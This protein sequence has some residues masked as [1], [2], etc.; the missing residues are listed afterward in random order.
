MPVVT[1]SQKKWDALPE[2]Q[3]ELMADL[4]IGPK[5][6]LKLI[7]T[8][9]VF[10]PVEYTL[11]A[12]QI[13]RKHYPDSP[14]AGNAS[15]NIAQAHKLLAYQK[16]DAGQFESA[17]TEIQKAIHIYDSLTVHAANPNQQIA[18]VEI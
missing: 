17:G 15:V 13:I 9:K 6:K 4:G 2:E 14:F 7:R 12:Y 16:R 1:I 3:Q 10:E 5:E 8:P 11:K 18:S